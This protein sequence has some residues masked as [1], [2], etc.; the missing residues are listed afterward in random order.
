MVQPEELKKDEPL[1]WSAGNGTEVWA[2]FC[3]C[4]AGDLETVER[5]VGKDPSL[6]RSHYEYRTP[7]Y[8]AVRE[9]RMAVAAF[10]LDRGANPFYNGDDLIEMAR[11]RGLGNM[12]ALIESR[13]PRP[14]HVLPAAVRELMDGLFSR[15]SSCDIWTAAD[16]GNIERVRELLGRDPSLANRMGG[17]RSGTPLV[18][19]AG[20]G[21]LEVVQLLLEHGAD[22]NAPEEGN[23][24]HGRALYS[25]VY[26]RH[27]DVAK[28]LLEHGANPNQEVESSADAPSIAI[29]NSD[30]KMIQLLASHGAIWQIPVQLASS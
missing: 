28:L 24:P 13:R 29:M 25:A 20:R 18:H 1:K 4:A 3:S 30:T 12:E 27:F 8:F 5:L 11:V 17:D 9:N 2:L 19:A 26:N 16:A 15:A 10:L 7:L 23:A 22:P 14:Q 6:V 21:H